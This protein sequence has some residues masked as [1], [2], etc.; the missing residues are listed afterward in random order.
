MNTFK[1]KF[2]IFDKN[3]NLVYLDSAATTQRPEL[4]VNAISDFYRY[5]N[6]NIHRGVYD[7][8][9]N[10]SK[11]FE[12]VRQKAADFLNADRPNTIAFT[13]GV[14][15]SMNIIANCF[16]KPQLKKG[17]NIVTTIMEHH[18]NF[19]PWQMLCE[20]NDCDFRVLN[21]DKN[22]DLD[23]DQ[24]D[25]LLDQNTKILAVNHISNTLGTINDIK[26]II[27]LAHEKNV[28]VVID[29]AQS[30]AFYDIDFKALDY[31]FLTFSGHKIFGPFGIGVLV[32]SEELGD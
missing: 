21:I 32:A 1:S 9:N 24:L 16:V 11:K 10:A 4:V 19:I 25:K 3:P 7:L 17:D 28:P 18:A 29:A 20:E 30:A 31:D 12:E 27:D 2:P 23:V 22:G 6:A 14:T 15:E 5:E 26:R 13:S 8:S